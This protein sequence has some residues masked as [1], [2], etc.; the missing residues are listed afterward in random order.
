M[1]LTKPQ[2]LIYDME[3]Y[4]QGTISVICGSIL[5]KGE[6]EVTELKKAVNELYRINDALR[7]RIEETEGEVCQNICTYI[8]QE[9]EVLYFDSKTELDNYAERYTKIPLDMQG[10]LCEIKIVI[11]PNQYGLL[12]KIH[13]MIGDA[14]TLSL[15]GTQFHA[16]LNGKEVEAYSY[17]D[18]IKSEQQYLQSNRYEKDKQFFME[19]FQKCDEATYLN[20]KQSNTMEACQKTF[21][22][23]GEETKQILDYVGRK[24]TS[25]FTLFTT[26]LSVYINRVKMNT[27]KFYIG[28]AILNRNGVKEKNTMGMFVNTV[29][30]LIELDSKEAFTGNLAKIE[31]SIFS[32]LRH[33]KYNYGEILAAIRKK[34]HFNEKLYDVLISYQNATISGNESETTWYHNGMQS[35]SLQIHIDD[36]DKE[37]IFRIHYDYLIDKFSEH[38]IEKMHEHICNLLFDAIQNENSKLYK[39]EILSKEE[40]QKLL[41]EFNNT[42][43]DYPK[44]KCVHQLFE[45]QVRK[46]PD[47]VAV[48]FKDKK[49]TYLQLNT[50]I[51]NYA[52]RLVQLGI[53]EKDVVAVHLERSH[54]LILFQMAVLKIGGIFLPV[55]K[56]YPIERIKYMCEDCGV[57]FLISDQIRKKEIQANVISLD[58]FERIEAEH[59]ACTIKNTGIC[60]IIY[61]SGST[62]TPKGCMLTGKGIV[63]FCKNNNVL[64]TLNMYDNNIFACVNS[65][66]FDYFIAE[67]LLPLTNG[68]TT[69]VLDDNESTMQE[70][71][72]NIVEKK[73]INVVMTTPTKLKI[74]FDDKCAC[75]SLQQL[76]CICTSGEPLMPELLIKMY[77]KSPIAQIYNPIGPSE[78]SVWDIGGKL[79]REDGMDIHIGKPIANTQI[80]ITD[81]YMNLTPIGVTGELCIA[82]D[83]VGAGYLNRPELTAEK[84]IDNPFGERKLYKT[85]DLAYWREDGNIV[86][87]GRNDFQVKIRGLRIELGEI[88]NAI[89][90]INGIS[91]AVV[92]VRKNTEGRQII[93]AFYTGEETEPKEIRKEIG[94]KLPK[95]MLPHIFTYLKEMPLTSNGKINRKDLPQIDLENMVNDTEYTAPEN[96]KQKELCRIL[97]AILGTTPIGIMDDFFELGGDSLKAIEYVSK[98]H[99]EGI[100][101]NLQNVFDYP[102]VKELC[103][104]IE[105]G[106]KQQISFDNVD[107][108]KVN[109]I[110]ERNSL[111]Y[112]S[113]LEKSET[114]NLLLAGATGYLGIHIL[115]DYLDNDTGTAYC[116]VRGKDKEESIK[117]F[118]ELLH[119]YFDDKYEDMRRIEIICGDLQ[120]ENFG[121]DKELYDNLAVSVNTVINSAASVKHYGSYQYFYETNV[122]TVKC[123]I[124]FCKQAGARFIHTSTLSVSGN[125]FADQFDGY[126]S[127]AEKHFYEN[128][129]YIGQPLDNVYARSK[130]EAERIVLEA[131]GDGLKANI[132]RM[133]NLTNRLSDGVFQKNYESNAFLQRIKAVLGLGIVPDYLMD[134]YVEFT[135]IDEAAKA[136]MTITRH[137]SMEQTVFHINST[138][139]VYMDKLYS[140]LKELGCSIEIVNGT[141]FTEVL[142][143]TMK[144]SGMEYIFETFINDMDENDRLSYD[145]NIHIENE[146]TV[147]YLQMLGFEWSQIDFEYLKKYFDYFKSIGYIGE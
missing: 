135:P 45:K 7:I 123:L 62:G 80:Y 92:V 85:G 49:F 63:N 20:E 69:V 101:F 56:R 119:F 113:K 24:Q 143:Q 100:Y 5:S 22:L 142:R 93:C 116:I 16:A 126:V 78:C 15:M 34:F 50:F 72:L 65:V 1:N 75:R 74:Y 99:N 134:L 102:T 48:V 23:G 47:K 129:L 54:Q 66:S 111:E 87:V 13:H 42:A 136:V 76:H 84:F 95:Y 10:S 25:A 114:G 31:K 97:E 130:F 127:E 36:R 131:M 125:S 141:E 4:A 112:L 52:D 120:K 147:K 59:I 17:L 79:K 12:A 19:Q 58:E 137:F 91:Q 98:A 41:Y 39:L 83:G 118:K 103:Q 115:A 104:C 145:S 82:G 121:M 107:F 139:G 61:T 89:C 9:I 110:L 133:G 108:T 60:Y 29:P 109:K 70:Q 30:I 106:D 81:P 35:E 88:E 55:D 27:E 124:E 3:K 43:M 96:K 128:S 40:K 32:I 2:K 11:L 146:F 33:Q 117:R 46:T 132:M 94:K 8:E 140:M 38:E 57:K 122:E 144:K 21:I 68:F 90:G 37:G 53:K 6:W 71:F 44:D 26:V 14:W 67:S 105:N 77:E 51:Q 18:Y 138:K 73:N 64:D 86:Y 28:T